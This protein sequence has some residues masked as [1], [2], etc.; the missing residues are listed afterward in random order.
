ML[1][2]PPDIEEQ[3]ML[4]PQVNTDKIMKENNNKIRTIISHTKKTDTAGTAFD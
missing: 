4:E 1:T 3:A 2:L